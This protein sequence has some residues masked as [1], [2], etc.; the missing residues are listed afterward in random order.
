VCNAP[1][2]T[3]CGNSCVKTATDPKNCGGCGVTCTSSQV[4]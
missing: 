1:G 4:C 2:T 3:K